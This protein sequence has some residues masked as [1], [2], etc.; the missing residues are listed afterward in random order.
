LYID[1]NGFKTINDT[2]GH[3]AGDAVI[4]H[5]SHLLTS[6]MRESDFIARIGGDEFGIIMYYADAANAKRRGKKILDA[7]RQTPLTYNGAHLNVDA[8]LGSYTLQAGD[9]ADSAL[10]AAD[11]A[12]YAHK[13]QGKP[14][15]E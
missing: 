12:M 2:H 14:V 11:N 1:L 4:Q 6:L 10:S 3:A 7:I 5:V 8:A 13:R 9:T 15:A